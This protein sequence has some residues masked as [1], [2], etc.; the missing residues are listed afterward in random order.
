M[1]SQLN[2]ASTMKMEI[3][4]EPREASDVNRGLAMSSFSGS[5]STTDSRMIISID[6]MVIIRSTKRII[7]LSQTPP[8]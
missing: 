2:S 7:R 5:R 8:T 1:P 3:R 4:P 6:G